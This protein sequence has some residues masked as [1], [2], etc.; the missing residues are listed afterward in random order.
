LTCVSK[1]TVC[2]TAAEA[3]AQKRQDG[4]FKQASIGHVKAAFCIVGV[5]AWAAAQRHGCLCGL[6]RAAILRE[7]LLKGIRQ[8]ECVCLLADG[9]WVVVHQVMLVGLHTA[10]GVAGVCVQ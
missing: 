3:A 9:I 8:W 10:P 6:C 4:V 5:A 1:C 2:F 7:R